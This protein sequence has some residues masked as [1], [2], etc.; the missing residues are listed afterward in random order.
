M[1]LRKCSQFI[2]LVLLLVVMVMCC[3]KK[4]DVFA[5]DKGNSEEKNNIEQ[6]ETIEEKQENN[7]S[8][9]V[10]NIDALGDE[11]DNTHL[12][13]LP[14]SE[15]REI[16][17]SPDLNQIEREKITWD[18]FKGKGLNDYAIAG[19]MG[20][21]F[22]ES[23]INPK[24]LENS[25]EHLLGYNDDTYTKAVDNNTHDF[26]ND[27]SGYG[28]AQW[29][30]WSR[31]KGLFDLS[32]S[33][34]ISIGDLYLQLDYLWKELSVDYLNV[35]NDAQ[36]ASSVRMM[37]DSFLV[38]FERPKDYSQANFLKRWQSGLGY[39]RSFGKLQEP[40][41]NSIFEGKTYRI[42]NVYSNKYLTAY[43]TSITQVEKIKVKDQ[44]FILKQLSNGN[45]TITNLAK[46]KNIDSVNNDNGTKVILWDS[47]NGMIQQFIIKRNVN[48]TFSIISA[49]SN[50]ALDV[51][52]KNSWGNIIQYYSHDGSIQ[53][54][55]FEAV[56][57]EELNFLNEPLANGHYY[58]K[59]VYTNKYLAAYG[60]NIVQTNSK[61]S[62]KSDFKI[63]L[64][65]NGNYLITNLGKSIDVV[66]RENGTEPILYK[67]HGG[68]IQQF[69][70]RRNPNKSYSIISVYSG[71]ALDV[72]TNNTNVK[73]IQYR[74]HFG[75]L[76]QFNF[77]PITLDYY[78]GYDKDGYY[79]IKSLYSQKY[80][81]AGKE[82]VMQANYANTAAQAFY[83]E[84]LS[85]GNVIISNLANN[86]SIDVVDKD[87]MT[88]PIF[89]NSHSGQVQQFKIIKN[90]NGA[91]SIVSS[92]SG[93]AL[94]V[95]GKNNWTAVIQY[96]AHFGSVQQFIIEKIDGSELDY[97]RTSNKIFEVPIT[98]FVDRSKMTA[99]HGYIDGKYNE[100]KISMIVIHHWGNESTTS[101]NSVVSWFLNPSSMVS[102][103]YVVEENRV[104]QMVN[105][106]D[107]AWH[108]GDAR[109][110]K[111]S[112][113][114]ECRPQATN[115]DYQTV[116]ELVANIWSRK[117][118]IPLYPHK[119]F[120]A[121][122]CP[123][124]WNLN[125]ITNM[126]LNIY[127]KY[128]PTYARA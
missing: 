86:K 19:I 78:K 83:I 120:T 12:T 47:H 124:K 41:E 108:A 13:Q 96:N 23:G 128:A 9:A 49:Y 76:Q 30:F 92:Y 101:F 10:D 119:S 3:Q 97:M 8:V 77:E 75:T 7:D 2:F 29:T 72:V 39:L 11:T 98:Y 111:M 48:G 126:A 40:G 110:N 31:K 63:E 64:L 87:S 105:E 44:M 45:Y 123:G 53:Q 46:N 43:G 20:N 32:K 79:R 68:A 113:G 84:K 58:I 85:N 115:G 38:N 74:S 93:K 104:A 36:S 112:I 116:A 91:F 80:L 59:N 99:N 54:F 17:D 88:R 70:L 42:K 66:N 35:Y 122:S 73:L 95:G 18:Y 55:L 52:S 102:A 50:K 127:N 121:T 33:R 14:N 117:G 26:V 69:I 27:K 81:T 16:P 51:I 56:S 94:D 109:A 25:K 37:S 62:Y 22:C 28:I 82:H 6:S 24:N 106:S 1:Q 118:I 100:N 90:S 125:R 5:E 89:F 57:D 21:L 107:P 61:E 103:H 67:T 114:I 4:I 65:P 34:N 71:K 15:N 60:D